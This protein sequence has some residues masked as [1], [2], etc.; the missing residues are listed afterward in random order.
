[1]QS[2]FLLTIFLP[3]LYQIIW[4]F[5]AVYHPSKI[6]LSLVGIISLVAHILLSYINIQIV[7]SQLSNEGVRCGVP[8]IPVA[9]ICIALFIIIFIVLGIQTLVSWWMWRPSKKTFDN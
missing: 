1:M 9:F 6:S 4:G 2:A 8:M 7:A 3:L 5:K